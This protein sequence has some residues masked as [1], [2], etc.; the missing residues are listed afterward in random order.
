M[1]A[2]NTAY[3]APLK[4]SGPKKSRRDFFMNHASIGKNRWASRQAL[5]E[6]SCY[7]YERIR[8]AL[9]GQIEIDSGTKRARPVR[10][11]PK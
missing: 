1:V 2:L 11:G 3:A 4:R 6:K 9:F 8:V 10:N 7:H 5:R